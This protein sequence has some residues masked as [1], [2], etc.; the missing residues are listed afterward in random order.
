MAG[1]VMEGLGEIKAL[2]ERFEAVSA[3]FAEELTDDEMNALIAE[4]GE[5]QEKIDAAN[6]WELDR[7]VEIAMDALRCPPGDADGREALGRRAAP[8]RAVPAAA[9]AARSAAA[10]RADQPS[11]RRD[12]SPGCSA[13][14]TIIPAPSSP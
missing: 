10:R 4:Q 11:R 12:R 7:T 14:C 9:A 5:L 6:G 2:L 13:S 8:R 3:R 1:N